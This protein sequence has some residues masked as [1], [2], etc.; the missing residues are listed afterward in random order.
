MRD[1]IRQLPDPRGVDQPGLT[2]KAE[3]AAHDRP[4]DWLG[5]L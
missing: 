3:Y 5:Y 1:K 2:D 4:P